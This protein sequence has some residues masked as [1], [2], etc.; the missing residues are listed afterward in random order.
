MPD[1]VGGLSLVTGSCDRWSAA[2]ARVYYNA[3][4]APFDPAALFPDGPLSRLGGFVRTFEDIDSTNTWLLSRAAE[5]PDGAIVTAELQ[6]A[7]RGRFGR[8]WM[9]PRGS[10]ILLSV[11]LHE[12]EGSPL[13]AC[14]TMLAATAAAEAVELETECHP[15]LRWPNDLVIA[16]RK[17]GGVL[18]ESKRRSSTAGGPGR[19]LVI[20]IGLNCLQQQGHFSPDLADTA[21][22]LEIESARPVNRLR[23]AQALITR[24]DA[25]LNAACQ[26]DG[27]ARLAFDWTSR[28]DDLG[29]RVALEENAK[30]YAGTVLEVT[31]CGE[32]IVQV[33]HGGRRRF[34]PA[35]TTRIR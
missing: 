33:D 18:A 12:Q 3:M 29:A 17:L 15:T 34:E 35:T 16:R 30:R 25:R 21:T 5:L 23:V 9:A 27:P 20:G 2:I 4:H 28:C 13:L 26:P 14:A 1:R 32:L 31:E 6:T 10:S 7:G 8:R 11:L 19:S 24:L 22:S